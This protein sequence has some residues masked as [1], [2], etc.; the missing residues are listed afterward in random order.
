MDGILIVSY[1]RITVFGTLPGHTNYP[2]NAVK[3]TKYNVI[4]FVPMVLFE[5][6]RFFI[7]FYFLMMAC[8]Q[9]IPQIRIGLWITYWGP[10]VCYLSPKLPLILIFRDLS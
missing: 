9:F 5:Q 10:L 1:C 2:P 4:T 8:S 6:F 7:N 3:N